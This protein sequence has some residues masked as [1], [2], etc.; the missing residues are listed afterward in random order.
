MPIGDASSDASAD[1]QALVIDTS[2]LMR[3]LKEIDTRADGDLA[4]V[5]EL[6]LL[7]H[8]VLSLG[9]SAGF[10]RGIDMNFTDFPRFLQIVDAEGHETDEG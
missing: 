4:R 6:L 8:H 9:Q 5:I 2:D 7:E 3:T 10:R 1:R